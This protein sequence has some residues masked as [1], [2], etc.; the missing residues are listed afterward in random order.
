MKIVKIDIC[1]FEINFFD[2]KLII[3]DC[4][5]KHKNENQYQIKIIINKDCIN[6]FLL[7]LTSRIKYVNH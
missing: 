3:V 2:D 1:K 7:T 4:T 6:I 5:L